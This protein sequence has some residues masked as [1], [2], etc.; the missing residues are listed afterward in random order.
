V[1]LAENFNLVK[2]ENIRNF[3]IIAHID[4]GKSTLADRLLLATGL[5]SER[6]F[7]D[8]FLDDMELERERGIT[9]K[10]RSV[11]MP[12]KHTDKNEYLL[13]LIDTPGHVDF[14]YEVSRSLAAC[15]GSLLVVDATQGIEAQ[16]VA[17]SYLALN[18][19]LAIIPVVN[20]IDLPS[21]QPEGVKEEIVDFLGCHPDEIIFVSA[22]TGQGVPELIEAII[23]RIPAP[24]GKKE[25]PL[26]ALIFDS[27]Y[28]DYRG[29]ISHIRVVDGEVGKGDM[30]RMLQ[31]GREYDVTELGTFSPKMKQ[32]NRL[33]TGQVGYVVGNIKEL[34]NA[35]I[36]DTL[37]A[38]KAQVEPLPGYVEPQSM[39]YCGLYPSATENFENLRKALD[40]LALNDCSF[41]YEPESSQAL[42]FGFRCG[43]LG[44]L[45]MDI[46]RERLERESDIDLVTTAPNVTYEILKT[47]GELIKVHSPA[48]VPDRGVIEEFRE[49][50]VKLQV[51]VPREFIGTIMTLAED[52][53]GIYKTLEYIGS[54][55]V[56]LSY[57]IPFAEIVFDFYDKLKS[58]TRGYGTM[59]YE[60]LCYR[61]SDLAKI[62]ILVAGVPVDALSLIC[63]RDKADKRGRAILQKLRKEIPRHMFQVALQAA[64]GAK[65]VAR[66]NIAPFRKN[67]TAKCYGGDITRKRKLLEKQKEGKKRMR[68][69]G[70]VT[71]PQKAFLAVL[72]SRDD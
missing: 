63:V 6:D 28:D 35:N 69:V 50:I 43:F 15:E 64:V 12:Y 37:T 46:I 56:L 5:V 25:G 13:N 27:V 21:A 55:R 65:V 4:H 72:D 34:S 48:D 68:M 51:M 70:N 16:T 30:V 42:G 52:R 44:M 36:G 19:D 38:A 10:A 24:S 9:I 57:E 33:T 49:P 29:V 2:Q 53:R 47:S 32:C 23:K 41:T 1:L 40:R 22:K 39:V 67:V 3:S 20:K 62:D 58:S 60:L 8:Q 7:R 17:N 54:F 18:H 66:E 61:D 71:V 14:S 26:R 31:V 45:H 11:A 59:D